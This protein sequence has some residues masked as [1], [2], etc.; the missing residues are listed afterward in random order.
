MRDAVSEREGVRW[1][2]KSPLRAILCAEPPALVAGTSGRVAAGMGT[3]SRRTAGGGRTVAARDGRIG[4]VLQQ[5][6]WDGVLRD[7]IMIVMLKL[8]SSD[9]I[10]TSSFF[11][12]TL[13]G[14]FCVQRH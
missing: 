1:G 2:Q 9:Y 3:G 6:V 10:D 7:G 5:R 4:T 14:R 12:D 8:L 13:S 11:V